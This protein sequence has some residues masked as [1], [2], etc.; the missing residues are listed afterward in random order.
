MSDWSAKV[1]HEIGRHIVY[2]PGSECWIWVGDMDIGYGSPSIRLIKE[3]PDGSPRLRHVNVKRWLAFQIGS[4][5]VISDHH[6]VFR[7]VC[8]VGKRCVNPE[9]QSLKH[10]IHFDEWNGKQRAEAKAMA[11]R[12]AAWNER[13]SAER[14]A[15]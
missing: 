14:G 1:N 8:G 15:A 12:R 7:T 3:M 11:E 6:P 9:H 5:D 13:K 2:P 10:Q 4:P